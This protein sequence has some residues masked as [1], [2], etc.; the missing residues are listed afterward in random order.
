MT[1]TDP[2][3][4]GLC[5]QPEG[6]HS[7]MNHEF[8]VT[9]Q[10]IAKTPQ[11]AQPVRVVHQADYVLRAVLLDRGI[12]TGEELNKKEVEFRGLSQPTGAPNRGDAGGDN[13]NRGGSE[14]GGGVRSTPTAPEE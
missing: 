6:A 3:R 8:S 13:S 12:I 11:K 7:L 1:M 5:G 10:L 2:N 4:C 14:T 9:G